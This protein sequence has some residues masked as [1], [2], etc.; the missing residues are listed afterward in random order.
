[1]PEQ[2]G[3]VQ[4]YTGDGKGKTTAAIGCG[5]RASGH[6]LGVLIIQFMKGREY[7]ELNALRQIPSFTIIQSGRDSF[8]SRENP[9]PEDRKLARDGFEKARNAVLSGDYD[10]VILDEINVAVDFG[11]IGVDEVISLIEK[12]PER[13]ELIL[14]GRNAHARIVELAD[15]V[16]EMKE[17]KHHYRKGIPARKGIEF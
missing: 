3:L 14:T 8:V 4:V 15:L 1:M 7:G 13:L 5:L 17:V 12:K 16:S 11:L 6:G 9:S 10:L 2:K